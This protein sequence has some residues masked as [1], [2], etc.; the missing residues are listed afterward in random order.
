MAIVRPRHVMKIRWVSAA[1][2][3]LGL[4]CSASSIAQPESSLRT[5]RVT[6]PADRNASFELPAYWSPA[7]KPSGLTII[8]L[9]GCGGLFDSRGRMQRRE[10][11]FITR[12]N[13]AGHHVLLSDSFTPRGE[14]E[15]CTTPIARRSIRV[16][17]R[18][19]DVMRL[20]RWL[21]AGQHSLPGLL[22]SSGTTSPSQ[23]AELRYVVLGWSH[24]GSTVLES[25]DP[26]NWPNDLR[27]PTGLVAFYPGCRPYVGRWPSP[28]APMRL[29]LGEADNWT[30]A[31][32][33]LRMVEGL[34]KASDTR[35]S[36]YQNANHGFD[37]PDGPIR[38]RTEL[39]TGSDGRPIRAGAEP[40]A[41]E[42]A[43]RELFDWLAQ[44]AR[45]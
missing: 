38:E 20:V 4:L 45:L 42:A 14:R 19:D 33:C 24:G 32:E 43:Y 6:I 17:D 12:A 31:S 3:L 40:T 34:S 39:R 28:L 11:A 27:H 26:K 13:E 10:T 41:R 9:H 16:S 23:T 37:G 30:P 25:A 22:A 5:Q 2:V 1:R 21:T 35:Y 29:Y 36:L 15:V 8:A 18:R 44:L 7:A